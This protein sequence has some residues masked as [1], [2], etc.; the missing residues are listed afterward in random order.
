MSHERDSI[1]AYEK[2]IKAIVNSDCYYHAKQV[3]QLEPFLMAVFPTHASNIIAP[4][5]NAAGDNQEKLFQKVFLYDT[6][7]NS[8][9]PAL[10]LLLAF[11]YGESIGTPENH[12]E[13]FKWY[14]KAA[15]QGL[16]AAQYNLAF[17]YNKGKGTEKNLTKALK[18][19]KKAYGQHYPNAQFLLN[20]LLSK[21]IDDKYLLAKNENGEYLFN[22]FINKQAYEAF[23][24]KEFVA[25]LSDTLILLDNLRKESQQDALNLIKSLLDCQAFPDKN[26]TIPADFLYPM[27]KKLARLLD[28]EDGDDSHITYV[29]QCLKH[30]YSDELDIPIVAFGIKAGTRRLLIETGRDI[31]KSIEQE[32]SEKESLQTI[33]SLKARIAELERKNIE[34]TRVSEDKMDIETPQGR[35][36]KWT[37][38]NPAK[39]HL[40]NRNAR[41]DSDDSDESPQKRQKVENFFR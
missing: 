5:K 6:N 16:A 21:G 11:L 3:E 26:L 14:K 18:W 1:I 32:K 24:G 40:R 15:E 23:S 35:Q 29:A 28:L 2:A 30:Y 4:T 27:A 9:K 37:Y 13:A 25:P 17:C 34:L 8:N 41:S 33:P 12:E 22:P 36:W 39:E 38:E 20:I 19:A 10:Q 31:E 7:Y